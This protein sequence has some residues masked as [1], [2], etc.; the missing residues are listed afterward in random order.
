MSPASPGGAG[1]GR[2]AWMDPATQDAT[3]DE[4]RFARKLG[5]PETE[6]SF[7]RVADVACCHQQGRKRFARAARA[8]SASPAAEGPR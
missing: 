1:V 3:P 6:I 8:R 2:P 5:F 4:R 7:G